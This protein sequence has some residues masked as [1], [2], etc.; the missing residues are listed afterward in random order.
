MQT[1]PQATPSHAC[2]ASIRCRSSLLGSRLLRPS[3]S[4]F[5]SFR[6]STA[7]T[8]SSPISRP[9]YSPRASSPRSRSSPERTRTKVRIRRSAA[10]ASGGCELMSTYRNRLHA[11][12][13]LDGRT[14]H[15]VPHG[16]GPALHDP[17]ACELPARCRDAHAALP[18]R[19]C[20]WITLR[21]WER[22]VRFEQSVQAGS[23]A[24]RRRVVPGPAASVDPSSVRCGCQDVR[25]PLHG[26]ECRNHSEQRRYAR[27]P[28]SAQVD[29]LLS[30]SQS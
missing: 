25:I 3:L 26:P 22:D 9:S 20:A 27:S 15:T 5:C 7:R 29:E 6:L 30:R 10:V 2:R 19:C 8:A 17:P 24:S 12:D 21:H 13:N 28:L 1:L 23:C 4:H 11:Y 16:R 14:G 18:R